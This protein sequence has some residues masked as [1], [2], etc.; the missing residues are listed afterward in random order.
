MTA[1]VHSAKRIA[2]VSL[3]SADADAL[4]E[5]YVA[6]GFER[7]GI[8]LRGGPMF[9]HLAHLAHAEAR[10][11]LLKLGEEG[12]ELATFSKP[13]RPYPSAGASNDPWFQHFA[14]VVASMEAAYERLR[15][16]LGWTPITHAGPQRLPESS[17]GVSA[18]KFRDPEGHPLEL[19]EFPPESVPPL[20]RARIERAQ[21]ANANPF[22][23]I[24]HSAIVVASTA[25][26]LEFYE[27]RLGFARIGGSF[28]RGTEQANLD[29][30][31]EPEVEVTALAAAPEPPH[32][33]L[34][35]Y[36]SPST[37]AA[38]AAPFEIC[39]VAATRLLIE[40]ESAAAI[41][42]MH[43]PDGHALILAPRA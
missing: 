3:T 24:D 4:A 20:W 7:V 16:V 38:L 30:L 26:S 33:E 27:R 32:L 5:F 21:L 25:R 37:R 42:L 14:I 43:D 2:G 13:G 8:E 17:G 12:L 36:R 11:V 40:I 6:L 9:A 31:R 19:L 39:D 10:V 23:G 34:L 15:R 1:P 22:L 41:E 29:A 35:C 28:N 18:F